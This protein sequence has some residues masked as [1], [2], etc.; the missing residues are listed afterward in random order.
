MIINADLHIHS[1]FSRAP[2][3]KITVEIPSSTSNKI[4]IETISLEAP[5]KGIDIVGTGDCLHSEWMREIKT[6]NVVDDGTFELNGTRFILSTEIETKNRIHHLLYFPSFSSVEEFKRIIKHFSKNLEIDGRPNVNM[7]GEELVSIA[8]E[9]DALVGPAHAFT[10]WT[11]IYAHYDSLRECYG[12]L[13][14]YVSFVE[15]GLSADSDYADKIQ[16]LHR[17]T[18]LT[19]SDSHSPHPVRFAREFNRFEVRDVTFDEI[20]KAILRTGGNKPVLNVGLPPQEGKYN[21]SACVSCHTHYT[22]EEALQ[23]NWKCS[24]GKRIK[25]GLKDKITEQATFAKPQHPVHRPPYVHLIPL[26]EII[27]KAVGQRNPF[28]ETT[29][30][31]WGELVSEFGSE[32]N[33]LL[34][35][36]VS[37]IAKV[38]VPAVTEAIQAFREGKAVIN[39]GGGGKYGTIEFPCEGD[40]LTVSLAHE[41]E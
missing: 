17:L 4:N 36:D 40:M 15:L 38:T 32:I 2:G 21:E 24:C 41:E 3:D 35:V 33:I 6:C 1:Y 12:D 8:R 28:T 23:R 7:G 30:K 37:D 20:K 5:R 19:N 31:R 22:L 34:D 16:E 29:S 27:T 25:K 10:P 9:V 13:A 39:P 18:F 14:D 26:S 11:G